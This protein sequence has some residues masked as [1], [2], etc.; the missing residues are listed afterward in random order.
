M[1]VR[2]V[3][4][5]QVCVSGVLPYS[6]KRS[7][8]AVGCFFQK[9]PLSLAATKSVSSIGAAA[10]VAAVFQ[11]SALV[12]A[13]DGVCVWLLHSRR[14]HLDNVFTSNATINHTSPDLIPGVRSI[15]VARRAALIMAHLAASSRVRSIQL[16]LLCDASDFQFGTD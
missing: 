4:M 5:Y 14:S 7:R 12:P 10:A 8:K 1:C 3:C 9:Q 13:V 6:Q 15:T 11:A 16:Y 2:G